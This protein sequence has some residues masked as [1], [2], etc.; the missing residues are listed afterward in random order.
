MGP[1]P[2]LCLRVTP[3]TVGLLWQTQAQS[4][5]HLLLQPKAYSTPFRLSLHSESQSFPQVCPLKPKFQHLA[6][7]PTSRHASG[8]GVQQ[9]GQARPCQPLSVLPVAGWLLHSPLS[10]WSSLAGPADLPLSEGSSQCERTFLLSQVPPRDVDPVPIPFFF[11]LP[12]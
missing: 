5:V 4:C 9:G 12:S 8:W 1:C 7:M 2:S 11:F 6:P 10:L 3:L